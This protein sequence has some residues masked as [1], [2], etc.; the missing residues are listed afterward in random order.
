MKHFNYDLKMSDGG[1][2]NYTVDVPDNM[3]VNKMAE[4]IS[5][6]NNYFVLNYPS[7]QVLLIN[8]RHIV[9]IKITDIT[10]PA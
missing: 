5:K 1:I 3:T 10:I 8:V 2:V 6:A 4:N 9:S 7:G